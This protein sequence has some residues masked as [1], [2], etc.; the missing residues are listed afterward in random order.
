MRVYRR[1]KVWWVYFVA[2]GSREVRQSTK[3]TIRAR[4]DVVARD[5]ERKA[6]DPTYQTSHQTTLAS[7]IATFLAAVRRRKRS[8]GTLHMY[9]VKVR[10]LARLIGDETP[11]AKVTAK[12]VDGYIASREQEGAASHTIHKELTA[13]RGLLKVARR[14]GEFD[15]EVS[16]VMPVA[17]ATGYQP[18]RR[19]LSREQA[20]WL[21]DALPA[22]VSAWLAVALATGARLSELGRMQRADIDLVEA[23]V[24][25]RGTKTAGALRTL[26]IVSTTRPLLERALEATA[27]GPRFLPTWGRVRPVLERALAQVK[28]PH[29]SPNDL[30]RTCAT[31]LV[32]AGVPNSVVARYLGHADTRMVDRVYGR[33]SPQAL[34]R[35]MEEALSG[36][37]TDVRTQGQKGAGRDG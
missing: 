31:W 34:G 2:P 9:G 25:V 30:R 13:L 26:P 35:L 18:R 24:L 1:G 12:V 33:A 16:Q 5:L 8:E 21:L 10:H 20:V 29:L 32:E 36:C 4:A 11:L 17:Y 7:A 37:T 14:R 22:D 3:Q 28:L 19:H 6:C 15:R 23:T 27:N